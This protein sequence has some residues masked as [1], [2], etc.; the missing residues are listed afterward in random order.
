MKYTTTSTLSD[1]LVKK[2]QWIFGGDGWGYDIGF[3]GLDH[4]LA[5]GED[6]N[7][8]VVDTE[9]YSNTGGQSS[10]ATPVGA[11]A[12]LSAKP[13]AHHATSGKKI[14]KKGG[15]D[16]STPEPETEEAI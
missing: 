8:V 3:G 6:V 15:K 9:V 12:K 5:S 10:K 2:S 11:V 16:E 1:S 4:A 14:R 7:V 13:T